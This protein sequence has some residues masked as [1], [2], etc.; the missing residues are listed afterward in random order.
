V[1]IL[2]LLAGG[3]GWAVWPAVVILGFGQG[4]T[5]LLRATLFVDLYG[6]ERIGALNG[7]S[8]TPITCA[9]ALAPLAA[10]L[11]VGWTGTYAVAFGGLVAASLGGALLAARVLRPQPDVTLAAG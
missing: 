6:T 3:G 5:T 8:G 4:A 11:V 7:L 10:S 2:V 9:R 1:G